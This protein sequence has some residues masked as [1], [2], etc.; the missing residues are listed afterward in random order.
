M[1]GKIK[2]V[3]TLSILVQNF[4]FAQKD[5]LT[6]PLSAEKLKVEFYFRGGFLSDIHSQEALSSSHFQIDNAR[7]NI[8]GDY[9][10]ALSYRVRFRMNKPFATTTQDNGAAALDYA[11]ITYRF[12]PKRQWATTLGKQ[13]SVMGSFEQDI[14]PLYEY[15]FTD[16]LNGVYANVFL[17]GAQLSYQLNPQ[18]IVGIQLHNTVN[19]SFAKHLE[20]NHFVTDNYT[21]SKTPIGGYLYWN[22]IFLDG[23]F[24]TKYSYNLAQFAQGYY[25]HSISLGNQLTIGNHSAYLDLIY[26]HMGADYALLGSKTLNQFEQVVPANYTMRKNMVYKGLISRYQYQFTDHWSIAAKVGVE[27]SDNQNILSEHHRTNYIYSCAGQY[28]PFRTEDFRFYVAY[29]GNTIDY[30][31][32]LNIPL[33]QLHRIALGMAYTLPLYKK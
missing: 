3:I 15:I 10:K 12:G 30:K 17:V 16:Y 32:E 20:S 19:Q 1:S 26:S 5:T 4:I 28:E 33:E 14:N 21:A 31:K 6:E 29:I 27:F 18:H 11:Y 2:L 25:T 22:G 24:R 8:Q 9:N 7:I 13:L 23:M